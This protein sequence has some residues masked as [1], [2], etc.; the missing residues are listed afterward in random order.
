[1]IHHLASG[2]LLYGG[3]SPGSRKKSDDP[4]GNVTYDFNG[5]VR[6]R[7]QRDLSPLMQDKLRRWESEGGKPDITIEKG[8]LEGSLASNPWTDLSYSTGPGLPAVI[9][10][11][12]TAHEMIVKPGAY[13]LVRRG[14]IYQIRPGKVVCDGSIEDSYLEYGIIRPIINNAIVPRGCYLAHA[15]AVS[16]K[17]DVLLF[18]GDRSLG[19]TTLLLELLHRGAAYVGNEYVFIDGAGVCTM[20]TDWVNLGAHHF[21]LYPRCLEAAYPTKKE[22]N[23]IETNVSFRRLAT[24]IPPTSSTL[25]LARNYLT[26]KFHHDLDCPIG[27]VCPRASVAT[28]GRVK[29]VFHLQKRTIKGGIGPCDPLLI[30]QVE[31][32]A[33]WMREGNHHS[34]LAGLAGMEACSLEETRGTI[35]RSL[36][37]AECHALGVGPTSM[38]TREEIEDC[39]DRILET[40]AR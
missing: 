34:L 2:I 9:G 18:M 21:D 25:R 33:Y 4:L 36:E 28:S 32:A 27:R 29:H 1:M 14:A 16:W 26:T 15:S 10:I 8:K 13:D 24:A 3:G 23:R 19:K 20:Y 30:A 39:V 40:A 5:I 22:Q 35:A 38:T 37:N 12:P 11:K 7:L 6:V 17:G 31:S